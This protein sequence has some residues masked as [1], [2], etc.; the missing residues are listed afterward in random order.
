MKPVYPLFYP[1]L[2]TPQN[3]MK[4]AI[5]IGHDKFSP[6]AYSPYLRTSEYMYH[7]E[8]ATY[9]SCFDIYKRPIGGGYKTQMQ[10]L[11]NEIN[12]K[13]Y[14]LVIELHYNAFNKEAN[15]C[16]AVIYPGSKARL[17]A[18]EYCNMVSE[19][20]DVK[21]RGVKEATEGGRG[22]WFLKLMKAPAIILEPFFGDNPEALKFHNQ[23][24]YA[25][26]IKQWLNK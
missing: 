23:G 15:G 14:D 16:E 21:N 26:L 5:I 20:Y 25:E 19:K 4:A 24:V 10:L 1:N 8:A 17:K 18:Q 9:L 13:D 2:I 6:G 3:K 7:S 11:A 12:E 22:W